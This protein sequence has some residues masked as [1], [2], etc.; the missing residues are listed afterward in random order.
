VRVARQNGKVEAGKP[1]QS[2]HRLYFIPAA[3]RGY[4]ILF[5]VYLTT[6]SVAQT[7]VSND[8]IINE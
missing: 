6:L 7:I 4:P 3:E 5:V 8:R 1:K 2:A